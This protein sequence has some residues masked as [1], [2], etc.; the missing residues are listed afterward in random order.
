MFE[1]E[2]G[3]CM[4]IV[5]MILLAFASFPGLSTA[6]SQVLGK[7]KDIFVHTDSNTTT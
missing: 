2:Q 5:T 1:K 6:D 4:K 7:V 3:E